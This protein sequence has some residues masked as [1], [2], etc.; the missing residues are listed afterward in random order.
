MNSEIGNTCF[1]EYIILGGQSEV[2][3]VVHYQPT[4][5][6]L[7][8]RMKRLKLKK[9]TVRNKM[10]INE[11]TCPLGIGSGPSRNPR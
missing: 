8:R 11:E 6:V 5:L 10:N 1:H 3:L 9:G 7:A 2:P 4:K